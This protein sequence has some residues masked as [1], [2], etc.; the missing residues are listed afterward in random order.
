MRKISVAVLGILLAVLV[1]SLT[2]CGAGNTPAPVP[3]STPAV[4][5]GAPTKLAFITQ[6]D[7]ATAGSAMNTQPVVAIQDAEGKTV[8]NSILA[9]KLTVTSG[10]GTSGAVLLGP[11]T[12]NAVNGTVKFN[13]L[14]IDKAGTGYTLTA[15]SGSLSPAVSAPFAISPGAPARLAFTVQP[16]GGTAGKPFTTQPEVT[17]QDHFGNKVTGYEGS[18]TVGVT[19]ASGPSLS[20]LSG[21]TTVKVV[22]SVARFV[23]LSVNRTYPEYKLTATSGSLDSANS[24]L[25]VVTAAEP[26]KLEFTVEPDGAKVSNPFDTQPKVAIVDIFG[27]VVTTAK[28]PITLAITP[29]TGTAGAALSGTTTVKAEGGLGGGLSEWENLAID[30]AGTG[31]TLTASCNSLTPATSAAFKV[32]AP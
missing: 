24:D 28:D 11:S 10:T 29:G 16:S 22:D 32:A 5:A 13:N 19:Y 2:A 25:F 20:K 6:P 4:K 17:V 8:T 12:V 30:L 15:S 23:D 9:I 26:A 1:I 14:I 27:N 7:G 3:S 21:S 31:Y 18:V